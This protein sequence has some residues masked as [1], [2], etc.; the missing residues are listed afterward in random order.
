MKSNLNN[1]DITHIILQAASII[2]TPTIDIPTTTAG[3]LQFTNI[4]GISDSMVFLQLILFTTTIT[5]ITASKQLIKTNN[6]LR[7]K[8]VDQQ[9]KPN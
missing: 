9:P 3:Y 5:V 2:G 7:K 1:M 4:I 6:L 8:T